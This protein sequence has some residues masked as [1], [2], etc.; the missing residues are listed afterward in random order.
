MKSKDIFKH[1]LYQAEGLC[2]DTINTLE[3]KEVQPFINYILQGIDEGVYRF[4]R[5]KEINIFLDEQRK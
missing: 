3:D 5:H 2:D 4:K 1:I